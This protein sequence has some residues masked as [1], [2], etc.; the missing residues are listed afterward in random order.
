MSFAI[1]AQAELLKTKRSAS[2]WLTVIAAAMMP[3]ILFLAYYFKPD[4]SLK[5]LQAD[6]WKIHFG[7]G[8]EAFS[9]FIFPMYI[10]LICTLIPQIEFKNNTWKQVFS[11]PQSVGNIFFSKFLAIHFMIF[12]IRVPFFRKIFF[13]Q[14]QKVGH[15]RFHMRYHH[16]VAC[17]FAFV[18]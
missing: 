16:M 8:W 6:P 5:G 9:F 17:R 4:G 7:W 14:L 2:F 15:G 12:F 18:F 11:S 13:A 10:I 3:T 1:S